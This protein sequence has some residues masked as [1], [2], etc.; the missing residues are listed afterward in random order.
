MTLATK[1]DILRAEIDST[2]KLID[3]AY[4][5]S[6]IMLGLEGH[7]AGLRYAL[8]LEEMSPDKLQILIKERNE[9]S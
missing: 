9:K 5:G 6:T 2:S 1:A 8:A 3:R 7:L 4:P